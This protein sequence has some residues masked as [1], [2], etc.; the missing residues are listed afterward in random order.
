MA[1]NLYNPDVAVVGAGL[2]GLR[3]ARE[4][5]N[6]G[7]SC[8]VLESLDR[9]GGRTL[10]MSTKENGKAPVDL[11]AAWINDSSQTEMFALAQAFGFD[12]VKQ[13]A[14][15]ISIYQDE[16][17]NVTLTPY[18]MESVLSPEEIGK[19]EA[20]TATINK[21]GPDAAKLD[22]MT[23]MEF[24]DQECGGDRVA[25]S[26]MATVSGSLLGVSP[27]KI[28]ALQ[29]VHYIKGG[30]GLT[31]AISELKNGGQYLR[32]QQG[33]QSFAT[34]LATQLSPGTIQV[35]S[36]VQRIRQSEDGCVVETT[37]GTRYNAKKIVIS[38]PT[39][40][41]H[42]I[43]FEPELP[44]AKRTLGE[45]TKFGYYAKTILVFSSPWWQEN[46]LSGCLSSEKGPISF[47]R[48]S[49]APRDGQY[50]ITCFHVAQ[51]GQD[52]S[53]LSAERGNALF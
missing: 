49:C 13:R 28:S 39:S 45:S 50:S 8:V 29:L 42:K 22:S 52:W 3:A 25:H 6:S 15:G 21:F 44:T 51:Q 1:T 27:D 11:G 19:M 43:L 20:L 24:V 5:Q 48:D 26:L 12:L 36:P 2:S 10:S 53:E 23:A 33:C 4:I 30:T 41:Y 18:E 16:L 40:L 38:V 46:G 17:G 14:E 32:V 37:D 9:V 31:N 47:A 35:S 7:L 34:C